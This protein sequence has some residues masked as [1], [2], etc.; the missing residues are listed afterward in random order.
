VGY[1]RKKEK[2]S[3]GNSSIF[4]LITHRLELIGRRKLQNE[5]VRDI[6]D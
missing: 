3:K 5:Q 2:K 1:K 6:E 4:G